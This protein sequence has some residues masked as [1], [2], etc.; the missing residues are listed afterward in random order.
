MEPISDELTRFISASFETVDQL[1]IFLLLQAHPERAW[2]LTAICAR[3]QLRLEEA[4]RNLQK[5]RQRGLVAFSSSP[6][7]Q[8]CYQ[9]ANVELARQ[10][11][12]VAELDRTRPV[13]L[14]RL[15]YAKG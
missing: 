1:R 11:R 5:L 2:A 3:L 10:A 14:I 12:A 7:H 9:P 8:Y 15:L 6:D 4:E 13:T